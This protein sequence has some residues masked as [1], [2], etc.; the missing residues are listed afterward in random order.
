MPFIKREWNVSE[1]Q[2]SEQ[3]V[4]FDG[5]V[6]HYKSRSNRVKDHCNEVNTNYI[7]VFDMIEAQK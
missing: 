6:Y 5:D 3:L 2:V 4:P 1:K 7:Y